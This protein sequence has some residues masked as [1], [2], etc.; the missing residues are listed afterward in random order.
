MDEQAAE[1]TLRQFGAQSGLAALVEE[2]L[3]LAIVGFALLFL[4]DSIQNLIAGLA[5]SIGS[6]YS[7]SD[8]VWIQ[9][10][11]TRRPARIANLGLLSTT[12][13]L[14]DL[15]EEDGKFTVS[16]GTLMKL[17]NSQLPSLRIER[18][19]DRVPLNGGQHE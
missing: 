6:D 11:G 5:L 19:L 2:Y 1:E 16:G 10:N 9:T 12:F 14:Y 13:Y 18:P 17:P 3:W 15:A 4:K 8:V 7:E